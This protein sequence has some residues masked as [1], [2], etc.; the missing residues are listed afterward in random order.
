MP[1]RYISRLIRLFLLCS[2]LIWL[3]LVAG[4]PLRA[5]PAA[6]PTPPA[7][8]QLLQAT[9]PPQRTPAT[10]QRIR[11]RGNLLIVGTLYD[12]KPFGFLN[13]AG[14][15]AGFDVDLARALAEQWG[16]E[17]QFVPVTPSTRLQSLMAGQVDLVAAA[18]PHTSA[19]E[20]TI[21]FSSSYFTDRPALLLRADG[22]VSLNALAGRVVAA[23]QGDSA[24]AQL[25][26]MLAESE[27]ALTVLPFQEYAQALLALRAGQ[28][29]ALLGHSVHLAQVAQENLGVSLIL[30]I[31]GSNTF[32]LGVAPGDAHFRALVDATLQ[33]LQE[34]GSYATIYA[35]WF[36]GR[37]LPQLATLPG[38]WPY[39]L[40]NLPATIARPTPSRLTQL[41][42]RGQLVVGVPVDLPPFGV[43]APSGATSGFDVAIA[44]EF[45]QRWLGDATALQLVRVSA[46]T[47][48]P[49]L[50][51][52]QI[53][54]AIAALP[55]TW[56]TEAEIDFSLTYFVD[57]QRLLVRTD[58][59]ITQPTDLLNKTI[60]TVAGADGLP[61]IAT[62]LAAIGLGQVDLL[63]FQ[64]YRSAEQ[65]LVAGQVDALIGSTVVFSTAIQSNVNLQMLPVVI[66]RQPY[67]IGVGQFDD[68]LR[69]LVNIT[70]Q[71]MQTDGTY[72][73]IYQRW[74]VDEPYRLTTWS[75]TAPALAA[76]SQMLPT[77]PA[78]TALT[79]T[80]ALTGSEGLS[81]TRLVAVETSVVATATVS[82]VG[83]TTQRTI[84]VPT[85][86]P[87]TLAAQSNVASLTPT[88]TLTS[89]TTGA[90]TLMST[91]TPTGTTSPRVTLRT[92]L[93]TT[94][95]VT[96]TNQLTAT[97]TPTSS[98]DL[99]LVTTPRPVT[100]PPTAT[101]Q[102]VARATTTVTPTRPTTVTV[103]STLNLNARTR[104]EAAAPILMVLPGDTQWPVVDVTADGAWVRLRLSNGLQGWVLRTLLV[105]AA[106]FPT[107][108]VPLATPIPTATTTPVILLLATPSGVPSPVATDGSTRHRIAA[109]DTLATIAQQ[110]Y[111]QQSLW[112]LIYQT[113]LELIGADPNAIPVGVELIIPPRP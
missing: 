66:D 59:L 110:Y 5:F 74:F 23:I 90:S 31:D 19:G 2:L 97:L 9:P 80:G 4:L 51:A 56:A 25:Q 7:T 39:T 81:E 61:L 11:N 35:K 38:E 85:A 68:E 84:L 30:P 21:D 107:P 88:V 91:I 92:A 65:A 75:D 49:L 93:S 42:A 52:G 15:V 76:A 27:T 69:D 58:R 102:P 101:Q 6:Q 57:T 111:G 104:P 45:A 87:A 40:A 89:V 1:K 108:S 70:L 36:P 62:R 83:A 24:L 105:E 113:N 99:P 60:A 100:S 3:T 71:A 72:A 44:Q 73:A 64:E 22:P 98:T 43:V 10:I 41:R 13:E 67:A 28:A 17:V 53:D 79:V 18:L 46:D 12:Y 33:T 78:A 8:P 106:A 77:Q 37:A 47:A 109:T 54:L 103:L 96:P 82:A 34:N 63:P 29:D 94:S 20:A 16:I 86:T 50:Q 14:V 55:H 32:A 26:L 48:L 95:G 112:T